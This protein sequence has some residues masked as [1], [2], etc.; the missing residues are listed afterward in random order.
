MAEFEIKSGKDT[1]CF[2]FGGARELVDAE[3]AEELLSK[4]RDSDVTNYSSLNLS[5]KSYSADSAKV[6]GEALSKYCKDVKEAN[7]SDII[8]GRKED[9]AQLAMKY[10]CDGLAESALEVLKCDDNAMGPHGIR[11][12]AAVVAQKSLK[13]LSLMNDGLSAASAEQLAVLLLGGDESPA[14][15]PPLEVL[16]FH[17]NM[18][19]EEGARSVA[20]VVRACSRLRDFRFS[21]TR[22]QREGCLHIANALAALEQSCFCSLDLSDNS[23]GGDCTAPLNAFLARQ[24]DLRHLILRDSGLEPEGIEAL[25]ETLQETKPPLETLDLSGNDAEA[26]SGSVVGAAVFAVCESLQTLHLDDNMLES[27]AMIEITRAVSKCTKL[28]TMTANN[29]ELS[30]SGAITLCRVLCA[31]P[32]FQRLE[33]D[34]NMISSGGLEE[35]QTLFEDSKKVLATME[36]NDADGDE[37]EA[38]AVTIEVAL[39]SCSEETG[40]EDALNRVKI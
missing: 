35:I 16:H 17:N 9:E 33:L 26:D 12:C 24:S 31:L 25:S 11:A 32:A 38:D 14:N 10:I 2:Q 13:H 30:A 20:R 7:I 39:S 15:C 5:D 18:T 1:K 28:R 3:R 23:F 19:G 36:E 40:L 29:C 34:G 4:I 22:S 37:D 8:A 27:E 21:T 6:I